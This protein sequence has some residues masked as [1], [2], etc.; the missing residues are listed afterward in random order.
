[1]AY[2]I[3]SANLKYYRVFDAFNN[4]NVIDWKQSRPA[5]NKV[6]EEDIVFIYVSKPIGA[7]CFKCKVVLTNK[8]EST[9]DDS[10]FVADGT[11]FLKYGRYMEL[12]VLKQYPEDLLTFEVLSKIGINRRIQGPIRINYDIANTIETIAE[13]GE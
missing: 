2:Y 9:I 3:I 7:I 5:L 13:K 4:L 10:M 1:M 8:T 11:P 12:Q 6:E